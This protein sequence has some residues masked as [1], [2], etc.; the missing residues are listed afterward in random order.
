M[1]TLL[2]A[3]KKKSNTF[4]LCADKKILI[5]LSVFKYGVPWFEAVK[6]RWIDQYFKDFSVY[7]LN[8]CHYPVG[9]CSSFVWRVHSVG[10][11]SF[12]CWSVLLFPGWYA[13]M[14]HCWFFLPIATPSL[15]LYCVFV[16]PNSLKSSSIR[17]A[18]LLPIFFVVT[19]N[20]SQ[21]SQPILISSVKQGTQGRLH[22]TC[23]LPETYTCWAS[24]GISKIHFEYSPFTTPSIWRQRLLWF[25]GA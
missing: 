19:C 11:I 9:A 20:R 17:L 25:E 7:L 14:S 1:H 23:W 15:L 12:Y 2:C 21:D 10:Q 16:V 5:N 4:V 6:W 18:C 3:D 22:S 24:S 13:L 8:V